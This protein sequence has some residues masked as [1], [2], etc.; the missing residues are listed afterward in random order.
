M[1]ETARE[2]G[3]ELLQPQSVNDDETRAAIAAASPDAVLICAFG[4]LIR[5]P[6]LSAHPMLNVHPS[7]LPRWRGAAPIE[8]AIEA[9]D[10]E[11]G[12]TIM[13]PTMEMDA[14]PICLQRSEPILPDDDY[15]ALSARLAVLGG[16]LLVEALDARPPFRD[17]PDEGVTIAPKIEAEDRVLDPSLDA[18]FLERRVRALSPHI[19]AYALLPGGER[20]GVRRAR[21]S[22]AAPP[23]PSEFAV[24]DD[25]LLFGCVDAALELLEVQPAGGRPM[26][27]AAYLRG[28]AA[29]LSPS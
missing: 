28:H 15:G 21:V 12:V 1:A 9:G 10:S 7:L 24:E 8:R 19:G 14:G 2:L 29:A 20:L 18:A 3:I 22:D 17:Q 11:T 4:A 26:D 27:A 25:R 16:D 13:R 5:E 6:L 23:P